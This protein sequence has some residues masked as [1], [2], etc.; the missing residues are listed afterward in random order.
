MQSFPRHLTR[1]RTTIAGTLQNRLLGITG[2]QQVARELNLHVRT[3]RNYV[4]EGRLKATR[5]GKQYRIAREDLEIFTGRP[6]SA[7]AERRHRRIEISS[8]VQIDAISDD[9][10]QRITNLLIAAANARKESVTPLRVET[11]YDRERAGLKIIVIGE[12]AEHAEL[13]KMLGATLESGQ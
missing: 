10:A 5:I 4:R 8:I 7:V 11:I 6:L 12:L 9:H 13:L 3:V 1:T 2:I